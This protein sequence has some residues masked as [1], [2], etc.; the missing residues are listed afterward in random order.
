[1]LLGLRY[2]AD[3][4]CCSRFCR[5][6]PSHSA[7][8]PCFRFRVQRYSFFWNWQM[9]CPLF[10]DFNREFCR[11]LL[12]FSKIIEILVL[13]IGSW[14]WTK[15][16]NACCIGGSK[17]I[18]SESGDYIW[19]IQNKLLTL[20]YKQEAIVTAQA[21][22]H[23]YSSIGCTG[24]IGILINFSESPR[25]VVYL[26]ACRYCAFNAAWGSDYRG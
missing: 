21:V 20:L 16:E 8:V 5:P 9:F 2:Q 12:F 11:I 26:M 22:L 18:Y 25:Q 19:R 6:V 15:A 24:Q 1:M 17:M 4:N 23:I 14:G 7:M 10:C 3:S 13:E